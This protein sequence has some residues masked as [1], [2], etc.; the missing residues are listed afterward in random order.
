MFT[1]LMCIVISKTLSFSNLTI[2]ALTNWFN[3]HPIIALIAMFDISIG[4]GVL[5]NLLTS[6]ILNIPY[7][8]YHDYDICNCEDECNCNH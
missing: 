4:L 7:A 1:I 8:G 3:L 5:I 6:V 2:L